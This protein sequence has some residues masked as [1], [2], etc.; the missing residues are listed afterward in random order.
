MVRLRI[1]AWGEAE[2]VGLQR[3][4]ALVEE[5]GVVRRRNQAS[6]VVVAEVRH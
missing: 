5:E 6:A 4:R 1:L 3:I 2:V